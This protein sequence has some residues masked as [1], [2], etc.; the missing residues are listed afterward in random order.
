MRKVCKGEIKAYRVRK[1]PAAG[2]REPSSGERQRLFLAGSATETA[3]EQAQER[4]YPQGSGSGRGPVTMKPDVIRMF[5]CKK[6]KCP[7][8]EARQLFV[9]T[10]RVS[11]GKAGKHAQKKRRGTL[12]IRN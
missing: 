9:N 8:K 11:N 6:A 4:H 12:L 7:L 1:A 10:R 5:H 3:A 2:K